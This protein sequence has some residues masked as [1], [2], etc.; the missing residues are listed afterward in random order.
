MNWLPQGWKPKA[1]AVDIDG[2]ITDSDKKIHLGAIKQLRKLEEAGIPVI[3]ATGNVRAITYGLWRFIGASGPMVCENGGVVWHPKWGDPIVRANGERARK[4]AEDMAKEIDIDPRGIT[5]NT[6]RESE[7]CLF[8]HENLDAVSEWVSNSKYSDLT[9]VKTGFAIH[10]MEPNLS[11]GE[12]LAVALE[13]MQISPDDVLAVGDAPN[14]ISMFE[15]LGRSVAVGGCF[16]ELADVA[17]L[18]L[19]HI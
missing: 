11:K 15:Y 19:I 5:T 4:C 12:G 10:L 17:D 16:Q 2:T 9:V 7:W 13:K 8:T 18:S 6:W 1:V 14:D 3:L